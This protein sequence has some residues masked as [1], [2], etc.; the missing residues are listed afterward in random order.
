[1]AQI[2]K[3]EIL[4]IMGVATRLRTGPGR[5][6]AALVQQDRID[7]EPVMWRLVARKA[8]YKGVQWMALK[9]SLNSNSDRLL[10]LISF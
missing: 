8:R 6:P 2:M 1:M 10:L 4:N 5:N 9:R 7:I 3:A